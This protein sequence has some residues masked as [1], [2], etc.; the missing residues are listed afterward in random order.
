[1]WSLG[2]EALRL[3]PLRFSPRLTRYPPQ[4]IRIINLAR[5]CLGGYGA[6]QPVEFWPIGIGGEVAFLVGSVTDVAV[7]VTVPPVGTVAG[8]V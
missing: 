7:T 8:E 4:S 5:N 6:V 3:S 2:S 1:M